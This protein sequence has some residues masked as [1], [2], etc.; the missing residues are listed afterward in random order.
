MAKSMGYNQ[1]SGLSGML[2]SGHQTYEGTYGAVLKNIEAG[3]SM[4][5]M[6][7]TSLG[8]NG[9]NKLVV[10]HLEKIFVTSDCATILREL[11]VA[12]PAARMLV[13]AAQMQEQEYG[14]NTNFVVS[15]A[16]ELLKMAED[17]IRNGLHTAEI[18]SGFTRAYNKYL[19]IMPTLVVK[20]VANVRDPTELAHS[21]RSVIGTK[22]AGFENQLSDLVAKATLIT[23]SKK[24]RPS[25]NMDSV[26]IAKIRGGSVDQVCYIYSRGL[27]L[28]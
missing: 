25:L 26:R 3:K 18:L 28:P 22:Q 9:M 23:V 4:A 1:A 16:G 17:L 6:V 8:P 10:N 7:Q 21:I 5:G 14:D 24:E 12:H 2:K 19:E 27:G 11:E 15:F 13:L 20:S